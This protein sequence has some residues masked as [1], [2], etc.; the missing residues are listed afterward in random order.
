MVILKRICRTNG[1]KSAHVNSRVTFGRMHNVGAIDTT[2]STLERNTSVVCGRSQADA[3]SWHAGREQ[4][5][6]L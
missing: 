5:R 1:N 6:G 3:T 4:K 2:V